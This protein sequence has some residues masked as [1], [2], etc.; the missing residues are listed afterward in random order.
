MD[1]VAER[2]PL[3][4]GSKTTVKVVELAFAIGVEGCTVTVK[5]DACVPP[6]ITLGLPERLKAVPPRL[7]MVNVREIVPEHDKTDPKSVWSL[8]VGEASPSAITVLLPW[9]SISGSPTPVP[10][11][12]K[13]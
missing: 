7:L 13:S 10:W 5:S 11:M 9:T 3:A 6:T 8:V 4:D 12:A 2:R 1:R